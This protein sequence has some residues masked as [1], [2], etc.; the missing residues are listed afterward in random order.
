MHRSGLHWSGLR[1]SGLR[2]SVC[3]DQVCALTLDW[4]NLV[5]G[6]LSHVFVVGLNE[7][8]FPLSNRQ[9]T[10]DEVCC[11]LVALTR[12]EKSCTLISCGRFGNQ[13]L[14]PS[15]FLRW[16]SP[17]LQAQRVDAEYFRKLR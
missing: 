10:D 8:H 17:H 1:P 2:P 6:F 14:K 9:V 7:G 5:A 13:A 15:I 16:I 11:L 12:A 3:A 4:A